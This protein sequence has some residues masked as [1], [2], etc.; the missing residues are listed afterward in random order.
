M[1]AQPPGYNPSDSLLQGGNATIA[2]LMGGGGGFIEGTPDQSLLQ[3]GTANIVPLKGGAADDLFDKIEEVRVAAAASA[4]VHTVVAEVVEKM[5]ETPLTDPMNIIEK[6][7][8]DALTSG[9]LYQAVAEVVPTEQFDIIR[10]ARAEAAASGPTYSAVAEIVPQMPTPMRGGG[11]TDPIIIKNIPLQGKGGLSDIIEELPN[12]INIYLDFILLKWQRYNLL[13]PQ[14]PEL[15]KIPSKERHCIPYS[16]ELDDE[17]GEAST[18]RLVVVLPKSTTRVILFEPVRGNPAKFKQCLDYLDDNIKQDK[19][20]AIIFAPPF[21]EA[22]EDNRNLY[23]HFLK[24]KLDLEER[25]GAVVYL[26]T[27]NTLANRMV[28]CQLSQSVKDDP[29]LNMLEPSYIVYPFPR[30]MPNMTMPVGGILFS[31]AAAD[32]EAA[33]ASSIESRLASIGQFVTV[34]G[35]STFAFPPN[36][37]VADKMLGKVT[38]Y[39]VFRFKGRDALAFQGILDMRLKGEAGIDIDALRSFDETKFL[40]FDPD[41]LMLDNVRYERIP[42][43][44][45][46]YSIRKPGT[47]SGS[48]TNDWIS[49]KFTRDEAAMLNALNMWPN[50]LEDIFKDEWIIQLTDFLTNMVNSKCYTDTA[51]LTNAQCDTSSTFVDKVFEYFLRNDG[52]LRDLH[53]RETDIILQQADILAGKAR[54]S[55][56]IGK[57]ERA[58]LESR[59]K[60]ELESVKQHAELAGIDIA[61]DL[62]KMLK[63]PFNDKRLTYIRKGSS[64]DQQIYQNIYKM[65]HWCRQVVAIHLRSKKFS[66]GEMSVP[67]ENQKDG[68]TKLEMEFKKLQDEYPG[69]RFLW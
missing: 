61:V 27:Q 53:E 3:G 63:N 23:A 10:M 42:L 59:V 15:P 51:L 14:M 39:K 5:P 35:R 54:N 24:L 25:K 30:T 16:G 28:G 50:M 34:G 64:T 36:I 21:F 43:D 68:T 67:A 55:I 52:R 4:P 40:P 49:E 41:H 9:P 38:P 6:A 1:S 66:K 45:Q 7:R 2:P 12:L 62:E 47:G 19:D 69:W 37:R 17:K 46:I 60:A 57:G 29:I 56:A 8:Q 26:L 20:A 11:D 13:T 44:G 18:D 31:G 65:D 32:E 33:P 22:T 48:V 58:E